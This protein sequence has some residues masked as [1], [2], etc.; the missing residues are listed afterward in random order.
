MKSN[1]VTPMPEENHPTL[2]TYE[3]DEQM[4]P[5]EYVRL[6]ADLIAEKLFDTNPSKKTAILIYCKSH[7]LLIEI[8]NDLKT[9]FEP[10][11]EILITTDR[12]VALRLLKSGEIDL[13]L[14]G[15]KS[16]KLLSIFG[17]KKGETSATIGS[18]LIL[19][20]RNDPSTESWMNNQNYS[21]HLTNAVMRLNSE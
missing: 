6:E 17:S 15:P 2:S 5:S 1:W 7:R 20:H 3:E 14:H 21:R 11:V 9:V 16:E 4:L 13:L 12:A 8:S 10:D 18:S 19:M